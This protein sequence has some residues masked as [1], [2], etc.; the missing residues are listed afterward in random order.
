GQNA[1]T[2]GKKVH[3]K[4][5][6]SIETAE[7]NYFNLENI[8]RQYIAKYVK[9]CAYKP[10]RKAGVFRK[11]EKKIKQIDYVSEYHQGPFTGPDYD[12]EDLCTNDTDIGKT[13]TDI[14]PIACL[15]ESSVI[16]NR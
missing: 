2:A 6:S 16:R 7:K 3:S 9:H 10:L 14:R 4:Q 11:D 12:P 5:V 13:V 15:R 1:A 8:Q